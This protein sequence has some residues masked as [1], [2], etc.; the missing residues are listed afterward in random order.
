VAGSKIGFRGL[1]MFSYPHQHPEIRT[2][3]A[4]LCADFDGKYW[5]ACD[6]ERA[7]PRDFGH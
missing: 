6:A 2:A 1:L 4:K 5:Q 7:Y 3:V